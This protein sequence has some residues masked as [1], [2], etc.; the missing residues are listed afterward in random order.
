MPTYI[1]LNDADPGTRRLLGDTKVAGLREALDMSGD[2][3]STVLAVTT[4]G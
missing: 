3:Y 4:A 1:Y 2:D